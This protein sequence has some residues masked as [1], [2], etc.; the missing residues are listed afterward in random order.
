MQKIIDVALSKVG[1]K[2]TPKNKTEFGEW[3]GLDGL[4]WCGIFVSWCYFKANYSL[5][6]IDYTKGFAGCLFA[7][8]YFKKRGEVV[9]FE[10]A[11]PGDIV[12]YDWDGNGKPDHT[13]ILKSKTGTDFETVEGN[14]AVG[15]D[16]NGGE[17]MVRL[18]SWKIKPGA[19]RLGSKCKVYFIHPKVLDT[20]S[21]KAA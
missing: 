4:A 12:I 11:Q 1:Y 19:R 17:V 20:S 18:N 13:G 7:L 3:F 21:I 15:N 2:E 5:G 9:T 6:T 10:Q 14:T 8:N 16:S